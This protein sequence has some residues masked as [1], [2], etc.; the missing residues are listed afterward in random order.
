MYVYKITNIIN[1]KV[2][3]GQTINPIEKRFHRH[4]Q[5]AISNR[6]DTHL[7]RAIRK[8]GPEQFKIELIDTANDQEELTK[9]EYY[10]I[11]YYDSVNKGYNE[12]NS[13]L[14]CGGNT[15]LSKTPEEM[16][17]IKEKIRQ[18]KIGGKNPHATKVKCKNMITGEEFHFGSVSEM[19][20]F[21][22]A[23]NHCTITRRCNHTIKCLYNGI[24]NIAYENDEYNPDA[25][26]EK[27]SAR[28]IKIHVKNLCTNDEGDFQSFAAAER[29]FGLSN[30][31][32][33][34]RAYLHKNEKTFIVKKIYEITRLE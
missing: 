2:Y 1:N 24:W 22:N 15:Y 13:K 30:K 28:A 14:K 21:L 3:I 6:L 32:L 20:T 5:D 25:T 12:T 16:K 33:S 34:G 29:Y 31:V 8:Y 4:I 7:A 26:A 23:P 19:E 9:K 11:N 17:F 27:K 10:W 18:T